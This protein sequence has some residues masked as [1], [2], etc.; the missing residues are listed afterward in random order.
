[1]EIKAIKAVCMYDHG[2]MN[3]PFAFGGEEVKPCSYFSLR[4]IVQRFASKRPTICVKT[5]DDLR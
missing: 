5:H 4:Y 3:Q 2:F 1:M